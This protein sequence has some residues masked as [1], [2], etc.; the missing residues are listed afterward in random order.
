MA[1]HQVLGGRYGFVIVFTNKR[2]IANEV[3]ANSDLVCSVPR[4]GAIGRSKFKLGDSQMQNRPP[5]QRD[6]V[7]R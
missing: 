4:H 5:E 7:L 6:A 1:V 3:A 2:I